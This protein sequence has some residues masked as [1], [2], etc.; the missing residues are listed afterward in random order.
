MPNETNNVW[1]NDPRWETRE[2]QAK[3]C[4]DKWNATPDPD[5]IR[6]AN[7]YIQQKYIL[8]L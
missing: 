8:H 2:F 1:I 5:K 3:V 7:S 4:L 6:F